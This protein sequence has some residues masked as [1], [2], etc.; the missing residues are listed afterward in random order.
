ML[1]YRLRFRDNCLA[2]V[3][4]GVALG[5]PFGFS[6]AFRLFFKMFFVAAMLPVEAFTVLRKSLDAR[7]TFASACPPY[8]NESD[9]S[10]GLFIFTWSGNGQVDIELCKRT[11]MRVEGLET[12]DYL[13]NLSQRERFTEHLLFA[14][15]YHFDLICFF[16]SALLQPL[17]G[18]T[19]KE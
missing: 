11:E 4:A 12:L 15:G 2:R 14:G 17:S 18:L 8:L 3:T 10:G 19:R 5:K 16:S 13:D 7:K 6:F 9:F 1:I